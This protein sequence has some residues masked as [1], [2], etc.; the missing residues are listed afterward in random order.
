MGYRA[1]FGYVELEPVVSVADLRLQ[2]FRAGGSQSRENEH[3]AFI[4]C[5]GCRGDFPL[6]MHHPSEA[7]RPETD[8][9]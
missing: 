1:I 8:R 3:D 6:V 5:H 4:R 9:Q 2:I 7:R